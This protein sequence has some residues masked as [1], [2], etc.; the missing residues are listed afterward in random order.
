MGARARNLVYWPGL[1]T[2]IETTRQ[3]WQT[4]NRIAPSQPQTFTRNSAAPSIPFE[5]IVAD[6]FELKGKHYLVTADQLSGWANVTRAQ[7]G[8]PNSGAYGLISALRL[9]FQDKGVPE[10]IASDGG[11]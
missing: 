1:S 2:D 8:S 9:L 4:C 3:L 5:Q 10:E 7:P 11:R 6:Y